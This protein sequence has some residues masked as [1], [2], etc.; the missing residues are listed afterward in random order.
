ML[1]DII[2]SCQFIHIL[3]ISCIDVHADMDTSL[4]LACPDPKD[5]SVLTLQHRH[6]SSTICVDPNMGHVLTCRHRFHRE[7]VSD[8]RVRPYIIQLGFYVF[9]QVGHVKVDCPLTTTSVEK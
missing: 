3:F 5:T 6:R 8:D 1:L 2:V 9:H 4:F 7:W